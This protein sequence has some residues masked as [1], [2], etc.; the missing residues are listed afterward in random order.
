[1]SAHCR[2][3]GARTKDFLLARRQTRMTLFATVL[4]HW[5]GSICAN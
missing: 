1:V 4:T 2:S 5:F 3:G